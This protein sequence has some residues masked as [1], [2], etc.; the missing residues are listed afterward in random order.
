MNVLLLGNKSVGK[1]CYISNILNDK[2]I[3]EY[4]PTDNC[5]IYNI[6]LGTNIQDFNISIY[7]VSSEN[8]DLDKYLNDINAIFLMYDLSNMKSFVELK[9]WYDSINKFKV[10]IFVIGNKHDIK[11]DDLEKFSKTIIKMK[12]GTDKHWFI[13]TKTKYN[14]YEPFLGLLRTLKNNKDIKLKVDN[15]LS[16]KNN[17]DSENDAIELFQQTDL[18]LEEISSI[19]VDKLTVENFNNIIKVLTKC[20][21]KFIDLI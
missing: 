2:F 8:K 1:T 11:D 14:I 4:I 18:L 21:D 5:N 15:E 17:S 16:E 13:S 7:D 19:S 12:K 6:L 20:R 9:Q 3:S 10:P